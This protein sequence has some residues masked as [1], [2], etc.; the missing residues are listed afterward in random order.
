M[1]FIGVVIGLTVGSFADFI[2]LKYGWKPALALSV[3]Y[4]SCVFAVTVQ[5]DLSSTVEGALLVAY[6]MSRFL[7]QPLL[8]KHIQS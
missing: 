7:A 5:A 1:L 2:L 3:A 8:K 6:G 4:L